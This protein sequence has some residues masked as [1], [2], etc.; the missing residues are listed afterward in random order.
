MVVNPFSN[1]RLG[2]TWAFILLFI[3]QTYK[4]IGEILGLGK[5]DKN[6]LQTQICFP[7]YSFSMALKYVQIW[8]YF[9]VISNTYNKKYKMNKIVTV[10]MRQ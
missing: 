2:C 4:T 7:V 6:E 5:Q 10:I 8:F 3:D 9:S 1:P